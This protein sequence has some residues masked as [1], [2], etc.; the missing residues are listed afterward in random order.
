MRTLANGANGVDVM[1]LQCLLNKHGAETWVKEDGIFGARTQAAVTA[2]QRASS[3]SP[4]NG[5]VD[6]LTWARF[7]AVTERMHAVTPYGQP[8]GMSCWSAAATIILGNQSVGPGRAELG[9]GGGLPARI[10]NVETFIRGRGWRLINNQ[11]R[12]PLGQLVSA[13]QR[14][15]LW[16]V[17]EGL[18]LRHAVV[19]SGLYTDGSSSDRGT[20]FRVHDP[21]PPGGRGTVYGTPYHGNQVWVRNSGNPRPA[22]IAY[23]AQP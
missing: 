13:L 18:N 11:S 14:S 21:W 15:P 5:A 9:A 23:V 1:F 3:I 22:M 20:V 2:F 17:L 16:V 4:A 12:P 10:D 6:A 7:G 8:T 19:F